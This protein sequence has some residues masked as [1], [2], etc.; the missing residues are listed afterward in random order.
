MNSTKWTEI[1]KTAPSDVVAALKRLDA[2]YDGA[3]IVDWIAGLYDPE[4]GGF[5]YSNSARDTEGYLP[6]LESTW[7]HLD[8]IASSGGWRDINA[9]LPESVREKLLSFAKGMQSPTDGYFYHPQ[10]RQGRENLQNDRYGRDLGW[11]T[12]IIRNVRLGTEAQYPNYCTPNGVKCKLHSGTDECCFC[13]TS[14]TDKEET[15][16]SRGE[17]Q[18]DYSSPEAFSAWLLEYERDIKKDSGRAHNL[19]ALMSEIVAH[20]YGETV[21]DFYDR[22]QKE[23][24]LEHTE[25][26]IEPTGLWQTDTNYRLVWGLWKHMQYYNHTRIGRALDLRY[27][28]YIIKSCVRVL[29]L[30][31]DG[32]YRM[33]DLFNQWVS[34]GSVITN[35]RRFYGEDKLSVIYDIVREHAAE[36]VDIT[37][38][39]ITPYRMDDGSFAYQSDGNSMRTIYGV[40][41]A[42]G[43]REGDAN[44]VA[45]C[46]AMYRAIY[47]CLGYKPVN[48]IDERDGERFV[49]KIT[50]A[51]KIIKTKGSEV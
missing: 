33:N 46:T 3:A 11:A 25:L 7:Q 28:P 20:G 14:A 34:I 10:W 43:V 23:L 50:N 30:P 9:A 2:F 49:E 19:A 1:E 15:A 27:V 47:N 6:D 41:I 5:Y 45:L 18:P 13:D 36:L 17:H 37:I 35:V 51:T 39:K 12:A 22:I 40:P 16:S 31:P 38:K 8:N 21:L 44:A 42:M 32:K 24:Y 48:L 26:G 29:L 4:I